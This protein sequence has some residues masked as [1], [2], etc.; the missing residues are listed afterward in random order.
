VIFGATGDVAHR[1]RVPALYNLAA[2]NLL[3]EKRTVVGFARSARDEGE[4]R[5]SLRAALTAEGTRPRDDLWNSLAP[6]V[7]DRPFDV[8]AAARVCS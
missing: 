6:S 5:Q 3:P 8:V 1:K 7:R 4:F 2:G